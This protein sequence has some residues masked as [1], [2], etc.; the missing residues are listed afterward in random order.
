MKKVFMFSIL[1]MVSLT[2]FAQAKPLV[3]EEPNLNKEKC[4]DKTLIWLATTMDEYDAHI[5]YQDYESGTIIVKGE[6]VD[7]DNYLSAV[8]NDFVRPMVGYTLTITCN[9]GYYKAEYSDLTYRFRSA[10]GDLSL[11]TFLL[12][13][14]KQ[15]LE[16]IAHISYV[17]GDVWEI[18]DYFKKRYEELRKEVDEAEKL[19][20]DESLKKKERKKYKRFY[21]DNHCRPSVYS[22]VNSTGFGFP[23]QSF[24]GSYDRKRIGLKKIIE[25]TL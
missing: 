22:S 14:I 3:V 20:D 17:K 7:K 18:D 25:S 6:F 10:R 12:E 2:L 4:W 13:W 11:P 16:E 24:Y 15:E 23:Y 9:D 19:K 1:T 21:D 5:K 8:R